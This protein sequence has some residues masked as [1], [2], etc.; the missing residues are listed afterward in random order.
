MRDEQ[1]QLEKELQTMNEEWIKTCSQQRETVTETDVAE[2]ISDMTGIPVQRIE[3]SE[4]NKLRNMADELKNKS[5]VRMML[6][7]R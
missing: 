4:E 7:I 6:S 3:R 1:T 2:V 5:S